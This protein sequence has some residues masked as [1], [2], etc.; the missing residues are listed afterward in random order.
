MAEFIFKDVVNKKGLSG[1]YYVTSSAT[2]DEEVYNGVGNPVY[3][4]A[5]RELNKHGISCEGKR[6][7]RL[8]KGDYDEYDFF[9]GMDERNVYNMKRIFGG[10]TKN[11]VRK[12][13]DYCGGGDVADPWYSGDF[14]ATYY[15][16]S[17]GI[18]TMIKLGKNL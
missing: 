8:K 11:K 2:S 5:K 17:R 3:P 14:T 16:V 6:A 1:E 7:V 4:P 12:L 18:D 10:D 13:L 9:I 15:D